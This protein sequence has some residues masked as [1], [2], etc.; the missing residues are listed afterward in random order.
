MGAVVQVW[1][2]LEAEVAGLRA[3]LEQG[4]GLVGQRALESREEE[5]WGLLSRVEGTQM[6]LVHQRSWL[7]GSV[8]AAQ[9]EAMRKCPP[10]FFIRCLH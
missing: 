5:L 4:D 7:V 8:A 1:E 9:G 2:A 3:C 10:F 6:S